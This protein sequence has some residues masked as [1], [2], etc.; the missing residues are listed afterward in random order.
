MLNTERYYGG[1]NQPLHSRVSYGPDPE[2]TAKHYLFK[3]VFCYVKSPYYMLVYFWALFEILC[4][5]KSLCAC[6]SN[7][8]GCESL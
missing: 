1:G 5:V 3:E 2:W 8:R 4:E 6:H 7:D